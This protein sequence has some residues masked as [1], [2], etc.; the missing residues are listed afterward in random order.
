MIP[1]KSDLPVARF[2]AVTLGLTSANV[3]IFI[4]QLGVGPASV[5]VFGAVPRAIVGG[6]ASGGLPPAL[7]L[8]TAMFLHGAWLHLLG[9]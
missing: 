9:N 8:F 4:W 3:A 7:T 6:A 1:L 5:A 2:P